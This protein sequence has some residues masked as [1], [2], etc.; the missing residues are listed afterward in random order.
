MRGGRARVTW[1][2]ATDIDLH[3]YDEAGTHAYYASPTAIPSSTLSS[4]NTASPGGQSCNWANARR[5]GSGAVPLATSW[6]VPSSNSSRS[7]VTRSRCL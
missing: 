7:I 2:T 3:V 1:D 5:I 4:D 6:V